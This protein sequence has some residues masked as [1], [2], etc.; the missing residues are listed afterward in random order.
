MPRLASGDNVNSTIYNT[1]FLRRSDYIRLKN[2]ELGYTFPE[3]WTGRGGISGLK[4]FLSGSNLL[5]YSPG[6]FKGID[7]EDTNGNVTGMT[8]PPLKIINF[9]VNFEF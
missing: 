5:T 1:F 6:L 7:P 9:G 3:T 8:I 2:V 4:V